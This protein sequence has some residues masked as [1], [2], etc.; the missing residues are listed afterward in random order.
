[1]KRYGQKVYKLPPR[2]PAHVSAETNKRPFEEQ[3]FLQNTQIPDPPV[4]I[5]VTPELTTSQS[6]V[7]ILL[8]DPSVELPHVVETLEPTLTDE[9]S[10]DQIMLSVFGDCSQQGIQ[11]LPAHTQEPQVL[12]TWPSLFDESNDLIP[13]LDHLET[14]LAREQQETPMDLTMPD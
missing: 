5:S 8:P 1:M 10:M 6:P 2:T 13:F 12:H 7:Q 11:A 3:P 9:S 4:Q 14:G